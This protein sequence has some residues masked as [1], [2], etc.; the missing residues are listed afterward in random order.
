MV[1]GVGEI[2]SAGVHDVEV[3]V[4]A[5]GHEFPALHFCIGNRCCTDDGGWSGGIEETFFI[6]ESVGE[7]T[8]LIP[9]FL[10]F[11]GEFRIGST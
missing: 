1:S 11:G 10:V 6:T 8:E 4:V 3:A 9:V 2:F 7:E 5:V